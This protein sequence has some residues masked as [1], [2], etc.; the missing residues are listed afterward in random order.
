M[1]QKKWLFQLLSDL[2][3][4]TFAPRCES[5]LKSSWTIE[6]EPFTPFLWGPVS[7]STS[8]TN[9]RAL[10]LVVKHSISV[11]YSP[12]SC[13][14]FLYCRTFRN[15][16]VPLNHARKIIEIEF[17]LAKTAHQHKGINIG[18]SKKLSRQVARLGEVRFNGRHDIKKHSGNFS[19]SF[20]VG[21]ISQICR[22]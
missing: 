4:R 16:V 12:P 17:R 18:Q 11:T 21:G 3:N 20:I 5:D 13:K 7:D 8:L 9:Y 10:R 1:R 15:L 22:I 19:D 2:L 6:S 14:N